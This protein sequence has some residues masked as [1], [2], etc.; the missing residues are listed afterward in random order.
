MGE[1]IVIDWYFNEAFVISRPWHVAE[2][3]VDLGQI[4]VLETFI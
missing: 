2:D 3:S 4:D 1:E